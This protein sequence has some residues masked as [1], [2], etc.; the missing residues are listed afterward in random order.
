MP[1]KNR[2]SIQVVIIQEMIRLCSPNGGC[3]WGIKKAAKFVSDEFMPIPGRRAI[4]TISPDTAKRY[5][6]HWLDFGML[7][8]DTPRDKKRKIPKAAKKWSPTKTTK[9]LEIVDNCP[10]L[11]LDEISDKQIE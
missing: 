11:Y 3:N 10:V 7:P 8:C 4:I 6:K 9:L 1:E 5:Y 2:K